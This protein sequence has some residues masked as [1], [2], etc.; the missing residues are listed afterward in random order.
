[1]LSIGSAFI[2]LHEEIDQK[3]YLNIMAIQFLLAQSQIFLTLEI[4]SFFHQGW[5]FT[6]IEKFALQLT[7][8][9]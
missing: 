4:L 9:Y 3:F 8:I 1:M 5:W 7:S 2:K 6:I